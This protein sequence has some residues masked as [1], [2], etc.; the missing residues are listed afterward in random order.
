MVIE[1]SSDIVVRVDGV[2]KTFSSDRGTVDAVHDAHLSLKEGEFVSLLGPSGCGKTTLLRM[3]GDLETPTRGRIEVNGRDPQSARRQRRIG[4]VFQKPSLLEWRNVQDNVRLPGE[5]F[6]DPVVIARSQEMIDKVGLGGFESAFP[7]ELS[8]G[9]QSRVAIARA[10]THRPNVLLM[11]EPFGALDEITRER[12]QIELL[13]VW[14][15]TQAAVLFVTH[16]IPEALLLSDRVVVMSARPGRIVEDLAVPF[17]RPRD[18]HLRTNADFV[19]LEAHLRDRL[20][21]DALE[22]GGTERD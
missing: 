18:P 1:Q 21:A 9:M 19:N 4:A 6:G 3:V 7:R 8:G 2:Y 15:E 20:N 13:H 14:R 22:A 5:V 11:D 17:D 10:L 12:L 16:S